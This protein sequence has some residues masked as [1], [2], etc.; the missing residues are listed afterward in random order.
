MVT[1]MEVMI[2][3]TGGAQLEL[4]ATT[5][6]NA[7]GSLE[8]SRKMRTIRRSMS[9]TQVMW[10]WRTFLQ[11]IMRPQMEALFYQYE[12]DILWCDIG[13][14]TVFPDIAPMW[15]NWAKSNGRHVIANARC[16][17]NYS[18]FDNPEYTDTTHL[19]MRKWESSEVSDPYSYGYNQD[20]PDEN[21]RNST[22]ILHSFIDI[23]S[24]NGNYL[25]DIGPTANGTIVSPSRTS[26]LKVGEWLMGEAIYDTQYWY[27]TA[28]EGD[29]RF[30]TKSDAFHMI[31]LSYPTDGVLRSISPLPL[32][33]GDI[34]TFLGPSQSQ[35]ELTWS[36]S[37]NRVFE[38]FVD[39][40]ELAMVQ[41]A[42]AFK[43]R[44]T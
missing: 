25:I 15:F 18:D 31:S 11:D 19:K 2:C 23:V 27:V 30:T 26:L 38:L 42:W 3:I 14:P 39:E 37:E 43:I 24:K 1:L 33:D 20:T 29:L 22:Y 9:H 28:E 21:Y 12:T 44:Y 10:K 40:E 36:W 17:A 13:G 6:F 8:V 34:A 4:P 16:G 35:K 32:K 41:D 5:F 7:L